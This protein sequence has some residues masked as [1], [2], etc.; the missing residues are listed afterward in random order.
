MSKKLLTNAFDDE[1]EEEDGEKLYDPDAL[2]DV[3]EH[4]SR[5]QSDETV[6]TQCTRLEAEGRKN[7]TAVLGV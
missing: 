1:E 4:D 3:Y 6:L 5:Q 2:P 7:I